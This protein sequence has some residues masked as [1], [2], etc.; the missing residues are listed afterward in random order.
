MRGSIAPSATVTGSP[1][2]ERRVEGCYV[3]IR[4]LAP[5]I[6]GPAVPMGD[7]LDPAL[8]AVL[9]SPWAR[10][11]A[12]AWGA[13]WGSFA[14]VII[15]RVPREMSIVRPR[16]R[17]GAC[18]TPIAAWDNIPILS[19]LL[20]RGRCRHC[21]EP[22]AL[23][24]LMVEVLCGVLS[25]ALYIQIVHLPLLLGHDV[26]VVPWLLWLMFGIALVI[27]TFTD[28]DQWIIPDVVV[29]PM[30]AL[31]L[32]VAAFDDRILGVPLS[33]AAIAAAG[34]WATFTG[35]RWVYR[36]W[37]GIDALGPGDAKLLLMVGAFTGM[38]GLAWCVGAGAIQGLLVSIPLLLLGRRVAN[39]DLADAHGDDPELAEPAAA[40][41]MG[42]RVP[43]GPFLAL[44]A[45]EY[46]LL[47]RAI[48]QAIMRMLGLF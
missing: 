21:G 47:G 19:Y 36:R 7:P 34:G 35:I 24:Y 25:F 18:E 2:D 38:P 9:L 5:V 15:Y 4:V 6:F 14:N 32:L 44:A 22:F 40:G 39:V 28:L 20:L 23:R 31:G 17:C 41:V 48:D 8:A 1:G 37:R 33:E 12:F 29:L 30:A 26:N 45:L 13:I 46:A 3:Q 11:L 43:F 10:V 27:V 16:S 42:K